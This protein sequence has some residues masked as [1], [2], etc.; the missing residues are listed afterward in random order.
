MGSVIMI[1]FQKTF[2]RTKDQIVQERLAEAGR[3]RSVAKLGK[4]DA[5]GYV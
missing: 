2:S 5:D 1:D 4:D 3:R